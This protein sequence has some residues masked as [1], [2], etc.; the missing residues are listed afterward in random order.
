MVLNNLFEDIPDF[1]SHSLNNAF[2]GLDVV[3]QALLH[4]LAHHKW[5]EQ[6]K[7]HSFW[8][9]TLMELKSWADDDD[10]A[11]RVV[12]ALAQQVLAEAPLLALEH[13][14][15]AL[16]LVIRRPADGSTA[17]AVVDQ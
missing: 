9:S 11:A 5:L 15:Q 4:Q 8:K 12:D 13:V 6:L 1:W 7:C 16:E 3:R 2:G 14:G 10:A 17:A